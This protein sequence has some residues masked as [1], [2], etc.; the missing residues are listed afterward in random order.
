MLSIEQQ[1]YLVSVLGYALPIGLTVLV[2]RLK[3]PRNLVLRGVAGIGV[4]WIAS[5]AFTIWPYNPVGEAY[6]EAKFGSEYAFNRF[7][8]NTIASM[9]LGGWILPLLTVGA[10]YGGRSIWR[11]TSLGRS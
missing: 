2:M 10:I 6:T 11:R 7:D 3:R 8:N 4:A 1:W 5:V 9:M